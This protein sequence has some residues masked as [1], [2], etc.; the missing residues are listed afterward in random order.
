MLFIFIKNFV[1]YR[2]F[3]RFS[4]TPSQNLFI[5]KNLN[6]ITIKAHITRDETLKILSL[7]YSK[8]FIESAVKY[9]TFLVKFRNENIYF[10]RITTPLHTYE[11]SQVLRRR[12]LRFTPDRKNGTHICFF[13]KKKHQRFQA[14]HNRKQHILYVLVC[15]E[16]H[17][18]SP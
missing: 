4:K 3:S 2:F 5:G 14:Y 7:D 18:I 16:F 13:V 6:Q 9:F 8:P 10:L 17:L 11:Y 15:A 1:W 12:T